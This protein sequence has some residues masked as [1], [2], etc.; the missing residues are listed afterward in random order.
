M[1]DFN[2][3]ELIDFVEL[4]KDKP[5]DVRFIEYMPFSGNEWNTKKMVPF[6]EMKRFIRKKYPEFQKLVD[7][8]NDTSKVKLN[9]NILIHTA[10]NLKSDFL[11]TAIKNKV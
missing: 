5:I 10:D 9:Y 2:D 3:D 11:N 7:K 8:A 1:R 4:T 6:S